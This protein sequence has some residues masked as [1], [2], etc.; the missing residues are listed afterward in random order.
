MHFARLEERAG[1]ELAGVMLLRAQ[2]C[3]AAVG[4]PYMEREHTSAAATHDDLAIGVFDSGVGGLTVLKELLAGLPHEDFIYLGDTARLPY[5]T[6][7]PGSIRQ[8]AL[9]A[10]RRLHDYGVK[11]LVVACNTASALA[12]DVLTQEFA[13]VPVVGVLEPGAAAAC[14]ATR[15]G[16]IAVLAT[17]STVRGG[18]YQAAIARRRPGAIV[19]AR[20]CPLFVA[21]AEE[22]WTDG[23]V[24]EGAIHRYL[25][26]VFAG[27]AAD[28]RP[29]TL[30][31]GCTHFPVLAP[32]LAQVLRPE[33]AIVD[34]A[35]TTAVALE[36][37]LAARGLARR[38][39][40]G[41]R[42]VRLLAT[43]GAERF[44]RVGGVF[45]GRSLAPGDV[46]VVDLAPT[47]TSV[48]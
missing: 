38:T 8:Y 43:D 48:D 44:A 30:L 27:A 25:D 17:E 34:S 20:A 31:L 11:C 32:A 15:S 19:T 40:R 23:P 39:V 22:G 9:Q 21:L 26:D 12:L 36:Q 46:E 47:A 13:P 37:A 6:K 29:D 14:R 45:L 7:S 33:V 4:K 16:R 42:R 28:A 35:A 10:A 5:G 1:N 3:C 41:E 18:A 24:V 2:V